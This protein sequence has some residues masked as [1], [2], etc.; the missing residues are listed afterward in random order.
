MGYQT[1][2]GLVAHR[3]ATIKPTDGLLHISSSSGQQPVCGLVVRLC[4]L[5]LTVL[6]SKY[7]MGSTI[8]DDVLQYKYSIKKQF[9]F[10]NRNIVYNLFLDL[11]ENWVDQHISSYPGRTERSCG[12]SIFVYIRLGILHK[13]S[14][15][16]KFWPKSFHKSSMIF[17]KM[18]D[19][20]HLRG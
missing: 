6:V 5:S 9:L 17:D 7:L 2:D 4:S 1:I 18:C 8:N 3:R 12:L 11:L 10:S 13:P 16:V 15:S 20:C 14:A 19:Y